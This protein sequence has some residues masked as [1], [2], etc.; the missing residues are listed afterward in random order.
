MKVLK[1]LKAI[2]VTPLVV[3]SGLFISLLSSFVMIIETIRE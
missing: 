1:V 3:V 2:L